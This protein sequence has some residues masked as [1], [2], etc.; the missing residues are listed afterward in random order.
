MLQAS[1]TIIAVSSDNCLH[2]VKCF[3]ALLKH[4]WNQTRHSLNELLRL[5]VHSSVVR[6]ACDSFVSCLFMLGAVF[7]AAQAAA[8]VCCCKGGM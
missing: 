4:V 2:E 5:S 6:H 3:K 1:S 7:L 8:Q